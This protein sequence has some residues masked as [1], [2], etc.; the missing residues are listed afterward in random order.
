MAGY[1]RRVWLPFDLGRVGGSLG[2]TVLVAG[3]LLYGGWIA[4]GLAT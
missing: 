3:R 2:K 1:R 4:L